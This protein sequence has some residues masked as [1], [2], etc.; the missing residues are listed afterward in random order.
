MTW[1]DI[2]ADTGFG[3]S[4]LPYGVVCVDGGRPQIGVRVG[5]TVLELGNLARAGVLPHECIGEDLNELMAAGP[6]RWTEVRETIQ[7]VLTEEAYRRVV[8]VSLIHPERVQMHLPFRVSDYVDFYSSREHATNLG[9]MFRPDSEPLLENW[10]HLPVGYHGRSGTVVVSGTRVRRPHGQRRGPDGPEFGLSQKVDV[11]LEMGFV[12]G[13]PSELGTHIPV[14]DAADHIFGFMLVNDW[15][16]RDIQAWEYVPL[17]PFLGKSFA[18]SISGWVT[19]VAALEPYRVE[20]PE[21]DPPPLA[22]LAG[23]QP[24]AFDIELEILLR[25]EAMRRRGDPP[26]LLSET[27]FRHMY[28]TPAQQLAHM[29]INGASA[30]TG[31]LCASG[32]IS[33]S[34]PGTYGSLIELTWNGAEPIELPDGTLRTFLEDGDEVIMRGMASSGEERLVM[35]DVVGRIVP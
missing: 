18:T 4:H 21:Q 10:R 24:W 19:P 30:R 31:D 1:L 33:G 35:G 17:G 9:R 34:Q 29:T 6:K 12:V 28:W 22:Y 13:A 23:G 11:E 8:E 5:D 14:E 15:S 27:N 26:A 20:P 2:P 32:T 7:A 3:L 25:T 16:A